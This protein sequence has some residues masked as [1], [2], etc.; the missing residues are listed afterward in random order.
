MIWASE[1]AGGRWNF[2]GYS[3]P[4]LQPNVVAKAQKTAINGHRVQSKQGP[5]RHPRTEARLKTKTRKDSR[6]FNEAG[7][8]RRLVFWNDPVVGGKIDLPEAGRSFYELDA[9]LGFASLFA[10]D[11]HNA[12]FARTLRGFIGDGNFLGGGHAS[13][14]GN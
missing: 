12:A 7:L 4:N 1:R 9:H 14:E 3:R 5:A 2:S 8:K 10:S 11:V 6:A 13:C